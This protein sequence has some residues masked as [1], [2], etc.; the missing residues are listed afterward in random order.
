MAPYRIER[1]P[2]QAQTAL[3]VQISSSQDL[4]PRLCPADAPGNA[5]RVRSGLPPRGSR[6]DLGD[7]R[8]WRVALRH[9]IVQMLGRHD[10]AGDHHLDPFLDGHV[11]QDQIGARNEKQKPGGRIRGRRD[12]DVDGFGAGALLD[13]A[14]GGAGQ[15]P[16][17]PDSFSRVFE[18]CH[19]PERVGA[20]G[21]N[22][23]KDLFCAP[24]D[25][26]NDRDSS[27]QILASSLDHAT[28]Q[29]R[30]RPTREGDDRKRDD[31]P[32]AGDGVGNQSTGKNLLIDHLDEPG[33]HPEGNRQGC[34]NQEAGE[35]I[36]SQA[37]GQGT[38]GF[39]P[40][41]RILVLI[42]GHDA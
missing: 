38:D 2:R 31:D 35:E 5:R 1:V 32:D 17:R 21:Q 22:R 41:I 19:L 11:E 40:R 12:E 33:S 10:A 8:I 36:S 27:D 25:A 15:K 42:L 39:G 37:S 13:F 34:Q 30:G 29:S 20:F 23:L 7:R 18:N 3:R 14:S 16:D 28:N 26:A 6:S 9:P 4:W 24:I